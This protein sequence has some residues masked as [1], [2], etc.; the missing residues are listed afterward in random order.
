MERPDRG[1]RCD[2]EGEEESGAKPID[3]AGSREEEV[4]R[5]VDNWG[6]GEPLSNVRIR[7]FLVESLVKQH[8]SQLT[9]MFSRI[10]CASPNHLILYTLYSTSLSPASFAST[11]SS[12]SPIDREPEASARGSPSVYLPST[13][14]C[15][16]LFPG[17]LVVS[18]F[19]SAISIQSSF[20]ARRFSASL[21]VG[22]PS[23]GIRCIF[24][25]SHGEYQGAKDSLE[26]IALTVAVGSA[27]AIYPYSNN[28]RPF[29]NCWKP[30]HYY[31]RKSQSR[32]P[33][34]NHVL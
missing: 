15:W 19:K 32:L 16:P 23:T 13:C 31:F 14:D 12:P 30:H 6:E 4:G 29:F 11:T 28:D 34:N 22:S 7:I 24:L 3:N 2:H 9:T 27:Q 18:V 10:N 17:S 20:S 25:Q 21:S 33:H 5:C 26:L 8:T 1:R